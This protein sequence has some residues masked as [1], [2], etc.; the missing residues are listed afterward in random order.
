M[1]SHLTQD[2]EATQGSYPEATVCPNCG[3]TQYKRRKPY[4][5]V[6][7]VRDRVCTACGTRYTPPTPK[8]AALAFILAG[9]FLPLACGAGTLLGLAIHPVA[10]LGHNAP[11]LFVVI[12]IEV[13]LACVGTSAI[14]HGVRRLYRARRLNP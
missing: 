8:W 11:A 2:R 3:G 1:D 12:G 10:F 13:I 7:F 5:R 9:A 6:A 14:T 4:T